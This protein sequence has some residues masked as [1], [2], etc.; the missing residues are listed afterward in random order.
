VINDN[1]LSFEVLSRVLMMFALYWDEMLCSW[2]ETVGRSLPNI[3]V[4]HSKGQEQ[5]LRNFKPRRR[6]SFI[7]ILHTFGKEKKKEISWQVSRNSK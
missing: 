1:N 4:S 7:I 6:T 5:L 3:M 2:L